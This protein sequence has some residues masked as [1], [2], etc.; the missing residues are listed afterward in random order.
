MSH[1]ETTSSGCYVSHHG[2]RSACFRLDVC[3][4]RDCLREAPSPP[5]EN[6]TADPRAWIGSHH[7][8]VLLMAKISYGLLSLHAF[9]P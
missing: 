1:A 5:L 2:Q 7:E 8:E 6:N 9:L 4:S 3:A